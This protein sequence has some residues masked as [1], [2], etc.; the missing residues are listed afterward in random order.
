MKA[1]GVF[2]SLIGEQKTTTLTSKGPQTTNQIV[3]S[4]GLPLDSEKEYGTQKFE[5]SFDIKAPPMSGQKAPEGI[6]GGIATAASLFGLGA[7]PIMWYLLAKL[8]IPLGFD[9]SKRMQVNIV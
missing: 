6:V 1:R 2:I 9:V 4:F 5:Y 8:D 7:K 3:F